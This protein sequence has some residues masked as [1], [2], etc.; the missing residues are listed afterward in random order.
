MTD[1]LKIRQPQD[2]KQVN[3]HE[4]WE[5]EYWSKKFGVTKEQLKQAVTKVG[6]HVDAVRRQ[7]G[8]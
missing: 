1:N 6:P 4:A 5:L 7:L 3:V 8:K 2:G